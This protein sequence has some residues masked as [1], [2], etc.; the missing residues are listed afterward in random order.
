MQQHTHRSSSSKFH[1]YS[2]YSQV[3]ININI[4]LH[5]FLR[6]YC[7]Q[8]VALTMTYACLRGLQGPVDKHIG[9]HFQVDLVYIHSNQNYFLAGFLKC[10]KLLSCTT[11]QLQGEENLA[12]MQPHSLRTSSGKFNCYSIHAQVYININILLHI[13]LRSCC[14]QVVAL[15]KANVCLRGLQGLV[16]KDRGH[17]QC[18]IL[19]IR[20]HQVEIVYIHSVQ[21]SCLT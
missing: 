21:N 8:E 4:L 2:I 18:L 3:Y 16:H 20:H 11:S 6:S 14:A 12:T 19:Q 15:S 10:G 1:C 13:F 17:T 9:F 5:I 7:A